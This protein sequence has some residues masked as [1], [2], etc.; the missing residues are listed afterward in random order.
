[1]SSELMRRWGLNSIS[2][3]LQAIGLLIS[4]KHNPRIMVIMGES[5][6]GSKLE[7]HEGQSVAETTFIEQ[8]LSKGFKVVDSEM[9]KKTTERNQLLHALEGDKA[10]AAKIGLQYNAEVV[11]VGKAIATPK[12]LNQ[13]SEYLKGTNLKSVHAN[14]HAKAIRVD[15]AE[16]I[17]SGSKS[18]AKVH[19]DE[20]TGS[21]KAFQNVG[22]KLADSLIERILKKWGDDTNLNTVELT[23]SGISS[24]SD[25]IKLKDDIRQKL[26][27]VKEINQRA[28]TDGV[29]VLEIKA[30]GDA[31]AIAAK[32]VVQ[33]MDNKDIDVKDIT[34]N[35]IHAVVK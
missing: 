4:R 7:I 3:D 25:L 21:Y 27:G 22:K 8:F 11:I 29:A 10:L 9:A 23:L 31:Q 20:T 33:K 34:Q 6:A 26:R 12:H 24:Y 19:V 32:L 16:I 30:S 14:M 15:T 5:L 35:K 28:F 17:A 1:M 13:T 18:G 2:G